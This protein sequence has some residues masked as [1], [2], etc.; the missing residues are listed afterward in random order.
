MFSGYSTLFL[1]QWDFWLSRRWKDSRLFLANYFSR[2]RLASRESECLFVELHV[3]TNTHWCKLGQMFWGGTGRL[4]SCHTELKEGDVS[5][6]KP[7]KLR[8]RSYRIRRAWMNC[9]VISLFLLTDFLHN[10]LLLL[11]FGLS[12]HYAANFVN[13]NLLEFANLAYCFSKEL[14]NQCCIVSKSHICWCTHACA[15][16]FRSQNLNIWCSVM[17]WTLKL[18]I[19]LI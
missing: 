7:W 17:Y 4:S 5:C 6:S 13:S 16:V 19:L 10:F 2:V 12:L 14:K 8:K 11:L 15:C 1:S 18:W 9:L 3:N